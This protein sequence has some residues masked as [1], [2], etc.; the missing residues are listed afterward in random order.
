MMSTAR[1]IVSEILQEL[2]D[3]SGFD[4]WWGCIDDE[5]QEEIED[6][7]VTIAQRILDKNP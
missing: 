4:G 6:A 7:L 2:N 3:R 1:T 5:I